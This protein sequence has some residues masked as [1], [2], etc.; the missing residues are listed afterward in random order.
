MHD[1]CTVE[2]QG[3]D[4][5]RHYKSVVYVHDARQMEEVVGMVASMNPYFGVNGIVTLI[6]EF[7]QFHSAEEKHQ[8]SY[9][10]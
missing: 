3:R 1:P 6:E 9:N 10:F 7:R 4:V 5:G 2:R 8:V